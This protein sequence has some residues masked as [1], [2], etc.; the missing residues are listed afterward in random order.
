MNQR[1]PGFL[2]DDC[3][4]EPYWLEKVGFFNLSHVKALTETTPSPPQL[5]KH[6]LE[7]IPI[8]LWSPP[9]PSLFWMRSA[10]SG[11]E[12]KDGGNRGGTAK[13]A[14]YHFNPASPDSPCDVHSLRRKL[15]VLRST[16]SKESSCT[17]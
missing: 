15:K 13:L 14:D 16:R 4:L 17:R 5:G 10:C 9:L 7:N 8:V 6:F 2:R 1:K 3:F 11:N 12:P